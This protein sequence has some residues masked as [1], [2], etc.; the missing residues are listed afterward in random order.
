MY[1]MLGFKY[2]LGEYSFQQVLKTE[3]TDYLKKFQ[4]KQGKNIVFSIRAFKPW[5]IYFIRSQLL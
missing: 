1:W 5:A 4:R 2:L 3:N